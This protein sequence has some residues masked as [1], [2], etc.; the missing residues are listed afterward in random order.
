MS[1][2]ADGEMKEAELTLTQRQV[3][4]GQITSVQETDKI[5]YGI[6]DGKYTYLI[7]ITVVNSSI[8]RVTTTKYVIDYKN[9]TKSIE[10]YNFKDVLQGSSSEESNDET[11]R[12]F[13][14]GLLNQ[15]KYDKS[16]IL[17]MEPDSR[18]SSKIIITTSVPEEL[19]SGADY[20]SAEMTYEITFDENGDLKKLSGELSIKLNASSTQTYTSS[21]T[22]F[23]AKLNKGEIYDR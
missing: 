2:G 15:M 7:N 6:L 17:T 9:G 5:S 16:L 19:I 14:N 20:H 23:S 11:E 3:N 1:D 18:N 12:A 4:N 22:A 8:N 13:I 10:Q 21:P